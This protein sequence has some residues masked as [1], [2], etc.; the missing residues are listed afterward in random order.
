MA[1]SL[2]QDLQDLVREKVEEELSNVTEGRETRTGLTKSAKEVASLI[3]PGLANII[4]V[5]VSTAVS[6]AVST[7]VSNAGKEIVD[8]F[9]VKTA[10]VERNCL[11]NRYENDSLEQYTRRDNLRIF[12]LEEEEDENE[13]ILEAKVIEVANDMGVNITQ[14]DISIAHRLGKPGNRSRTVIVRLCHRK[15][16]NEILKKKKE[17]KKKNREIFIN[18]DLTTLR[19]T[20]LKIVKEQGVVKNATP[21][22]GRII[23]WLTNRERPV[24]I[25]NPNDLVKLGIEALDWKRLKLD[26]FIT[27]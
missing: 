22:D 7:A 5:A 2:G 18:E 11:V 15:K 6:N 27:E 13:N 17:L 8:K 10:N 3:M 4:T 26:H 25:D 16:R 20:L 12:G 14:S 19:A 9:S 1:T 21:R 23:A 24:Y